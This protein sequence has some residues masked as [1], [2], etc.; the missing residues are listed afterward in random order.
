[1]VIGCVWIQ[2]TNILQELMFF[3]KTFH[4][5]YDMSC[6]YVYFIVPCTTSME[7]KEEDS[8]EPLDKKKL[9][10]GCDIHPHPK[11]EVGTVSVNQ[12]INIFIGGMFH[13]VR[14]WHSRLLAELH[15]GSVARVAFGAAQLPGS[16]G[17]A[18]RREC[19]VALAGGTHFDTDSGRGGN[20][21]FGNF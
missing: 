7:R 19:L 17:W 10:R 9:R 5:V 15:R 16:F 6:S 1:M 2:L 14:P 8:Q 21:D 13:M 18:T 4:G 3:L 12:T 11:M 20:S